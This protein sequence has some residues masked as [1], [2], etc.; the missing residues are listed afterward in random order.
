LPRV[1]QDQYNATAKLG[2]DDPL[3]PGDPVFF[4]SGPADVTHFGIYI[5]NGQMV[6]APQHR[7]RRPGRV[8]PYD[9]R[10]LLGN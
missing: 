6:D 10:R 2:P 7:G 5:G 3:E 1:A 4:G 8:L 9:G